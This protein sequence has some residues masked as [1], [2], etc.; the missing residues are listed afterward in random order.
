M[1]VFILEDDASVRDAL[2]VF[3]EQMGHTVRLFSD[4]ES[5]FAAGV[6]SGDDM[7]I[8]DIGLPGI[9]GTKVVSWVNALADTPRVLAIT[10]QS[11]T[12]IRDFLG[13]LPSTQLLRKPLSANQLAH[14][15]Q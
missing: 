2:S 8:V 9:D 12:I 14:H 13:G 1:T 3:V 5:F 7:V 15:L 6:P 10:G 11:Q 4:A